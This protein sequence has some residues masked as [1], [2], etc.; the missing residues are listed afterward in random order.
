MRSRVMLFLAALM[1]SAIGVVQL[2]HENRLRFVELQQ[3]QAQR[4]ALNVEWGQLLLEGGRMVAAPA[5][6][7]DGAHPPRHERARPAARS[8]AV[9]LR[10]DESP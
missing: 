7:A 4:D 1:V 5:R 9:H 6:R 10:A 8:P 3:L 2:K